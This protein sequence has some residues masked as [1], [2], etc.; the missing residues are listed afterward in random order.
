VLRG[1]LAAEQT[2]PAGTK[3]RNAKV[4][5]VDVFGNLITNIPE[6]KIPDGASFRVAGRRI[7]GL[8]PTFEAVAEGE[9]L[10]YVG[11]RGV[12]EVAIR[13]GN[14]AEELGAGRGT[15]VEVELPKSPS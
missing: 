2:T 1:R 8:S 14:A 13:E 4:L 15:R 11:S 3:L 5:H 7:A 9:L 12:I 10:A 6:A